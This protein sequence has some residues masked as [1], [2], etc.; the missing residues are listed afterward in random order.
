MC[1]SAST[2]VPGVNETIAVIGRILHRLTSGIFM[3]PCSKNG[4][5]RLVGANMVHAAAKF[6]S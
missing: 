3:L 6:S 1:I 5:F 4:R 2:D